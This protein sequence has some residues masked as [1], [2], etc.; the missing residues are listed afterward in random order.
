MEFA[1]HSNTRESLSA[2]PTTGL[3]TAPNVRLVRCAFD[4]HGAGTALVEAIGGFGTALQMAAIECQHDG[5]IVHRNSSVLYVNENKQVECGG[6]G[7]SR[8]IAAH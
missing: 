8:I 3:Q 5:S 6:G 2:L 7:G 1:G 4:P